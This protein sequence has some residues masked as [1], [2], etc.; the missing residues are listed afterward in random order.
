MS[1]KECNLPPTCL[2][3]GYLGNSITD[4]APAGFLPDFCIKIQ[5]LLV[6]GIDVLL[7]LAIYIS[8]SFTT[9]PSL[10]EDMTL[11]LAALPETQKDF[12]DL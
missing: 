3:T 4:F 6:R 12:T 5:F 9:K 8:T 1:A 2:I 10:L 11:V 7:Q